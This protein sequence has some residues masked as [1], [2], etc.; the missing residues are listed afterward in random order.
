MIKFGISPEN[1]LIVEDSPIG[2]LGAKLSGSNVYF[3][4]NS[5]D[6]DDSFFLRLKMVT[7]LNLIMN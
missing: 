5:N 1:T 4:E 6:L 7:L 3:I 2:R